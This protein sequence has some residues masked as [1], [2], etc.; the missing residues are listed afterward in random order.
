MTKN[1]TDYYREN[2]LKRGVVHCCSQCDF[3]TTY[4]KCVLTNHINAQHTLE[5]DKPYQ[6]KECCRGFAQKAHLISHLDKVH[7]CIDSTLDKKN[8]SILYFITITTKETK[9][10]KTK[11]RRNY[12]KLNPTLKSKDI[13]A[14]IHCYYNDCT[15]KNHDLHYDEKKGFI[16]MKKVQLKEPIKIS[17]KRK[18][19]IVQ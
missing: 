19:I 6:C 7:D 9:S 16:T 3:E 2:K 11:A 1:S 12:Y 8:G 10:Y 14:G 17:Y 4:G 18:R 5:K 13:H 15:L